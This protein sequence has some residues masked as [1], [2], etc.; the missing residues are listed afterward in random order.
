[1]NF[2]HKVHT[3]DLLIKA[4]HVLF[5]ENKLGTLEVQS[6]IGPAHF[7]E[8]DLFPPFWNC[9]ELAI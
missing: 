9:S 8:D 6:D 5:L 1:M 3:C 2:L 7:Q 4:R